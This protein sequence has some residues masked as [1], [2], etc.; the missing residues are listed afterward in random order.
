M[1]N[2]SDIA[3]GYRILIP[4]CQVGIKHFF[5]FFLLN[6]NRSRVLK[7]KDGSFAFNAGY[8][9]RLSAIRD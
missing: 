2:V 6:V 4:S 7:T 3:Y 9:L 1:L 8:Q 5:T